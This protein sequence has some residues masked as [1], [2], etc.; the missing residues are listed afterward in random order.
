[1]GA[2]GSDLIYPLR[3]SYIIDENL[4]YLKLTGSVGSTYVHKN[5]NLRNP[6]LIKKLVE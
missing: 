5:S 6:S 2:I 1:M 4:E 3:H